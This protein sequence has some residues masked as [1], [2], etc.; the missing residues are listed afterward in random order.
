MTSSAASLVSPALTVKT[1]IAILPTAQMHGQSRSH[2]MYCSD[3]A[4]YVTKSQDNPQH[5]RVLVNELL[6]TMLA[7]WLD[8]PFPTPAVVNVP[9]GTRDSNRQFRAGPQFGSRFVTRAL[10]YFPEAAVSRISNRRVFAGVLA[11]DKWTGNTD[12]RQAVFV[13]SPSAKSYKAVFIDNGNS[14]NAG[15]WNFP[16]KPAQGAFMPCFP[17]SDVC[18]WQAF[19]PWLS[20]IEGFPEYV[21][22]RMAAEVPPEW[23]DDREA[24]QQ[25]C[26]TLLDRRPKIR[27]LIS[28]F[29]FCDLHPF[30]NWNRD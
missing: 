5:P 12:T 1:V 4:F 30:P 23:C 8:L 28:A 18:G 3:G 6:S 13:R 2:L 29:R 26:H 9:E 7:L 14:F 20:D 22:L 24:I 10:D 11:F 15:S 16:D 17:Y 25:L 19:E 21:L 27:E